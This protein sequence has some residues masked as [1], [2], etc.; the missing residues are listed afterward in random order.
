MLTTGIHTVPVY[1]EA[2]TVITGCFGGGE[3]GRIQHI[4]GVAANGGSEGVDTGAVVVEV[5]AIETESKEF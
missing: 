5:S 4:A 2:D 1:F 3:R